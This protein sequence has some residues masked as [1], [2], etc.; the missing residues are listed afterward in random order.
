KTATIA[1]WIA[2]LYPEL[3]LLGSSQMREAFLPI[4]VILAFLWLLKFN[5]TS[6]AGYLFGVL[7][8]IVIF[9]AISGL[10]ILLLVF[11]LVVFWFALN[12]WKIFQRTWFWITIGAVILVLAIFPFVFNL[13]QFS[14]FQVI[15]WQKYLSESASG[16]LEKQFKIMPSWSHLP[17]LFTYGILRPMLP[18]ALASDGVLIWKL[19][20]IWRA[21][22][23]TILLA[24][25]IYATFLS[26]K[27]INTKKINFS[28]LFL[29]WVLALVAS[30]W[31]GGDLWDNPRYR[32][33]F[34]G[35]QIVLACW[36]IVYRKET[37]DPWLRRV[38]ISVVILILWFIPWFLR[39]Y[40]ELPFEWSLIDLPDIIGAGFVS[41][42]LYLIWDKLAFDK[43]IR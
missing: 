22:G 7:G 14:W 16:W 33:S 8:T 27:N 35:L 30:F 5:Q 24:F 39:R 11:S 13:S 18:S 6:Q 23:W 43:K 29:V 17:F 40:V 26:I 41:I 9:S 3:V 25:L 34:A 19:I 20:G 21:L 1:T 37:E 10:I 38:I 42:A 31:G 36:G 2:F 12:E 15:S 32:V 4:L 28:L